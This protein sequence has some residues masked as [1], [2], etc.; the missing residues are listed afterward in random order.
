MNIP[1]NE[2]ATSEACDQMINY[3]LVRKTNRAASTS[4]S[5]LVCLCVGIVFPFDRPRKKLVYQI[6]RIRNRHVT[7]VG[8]LLHKLSEIGCVLVLILCS[9]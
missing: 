1:W 7:T 4:F 3:F 9:H 8:V 5:T 6:I 2:L